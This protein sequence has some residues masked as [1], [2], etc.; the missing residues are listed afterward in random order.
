ML[1]AIEED[2]EKSSLLRK[3]FYKADNKGKQ[4]SFEQKNTNTHNA[5]KAINTRCYLI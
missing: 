3:R 2:I 5:I 1:E 4:D